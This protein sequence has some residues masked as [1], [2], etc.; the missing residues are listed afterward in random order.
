VA[1]STITIQKATPTIQVSGYSTPFDGLAHTTTGQVYGLG[2]LDLGQAVITYQGGSAPVHGGT[3]TV[4][5]SFAG[6]DNY[7]AATS[8][9]TITITR[10]AATIDVQPA[11]A[12]YD[13][14]AH[15]TSG[16]IY[17]LGGVVIGSATMSYSGGSTPVHAGSYTAT[18]T[19]DG[20]DDYTPATA[21][22]SILINKVAP[23]VTFSPVDVPFSGRVPNFTV[24]ATGLGGEDLGLATIS[25]EI[26]SA[27]TAVGVY[28]ATALFAGNSDY[29]SAVAS[30]T[31]TIH[32]VAATTL[33]LSGSAV[34]YGS[35]AVITLT[36][37]AASGTPTGSV[38][39]TVDSGTPISANLVDGVATF[40]IP[41]LHAGSHTI[42]G[43]YEVTDLYGTSTA[44]VNYTVNQ[45]AVTLTLGNTSQVYGTPA[46]LTTALPG[47]L[48]TGINGENLQIAYSSLGNIA[49]ATVGNYAITG[50]ASTGTGLLS[51][52]DITL[53]NGTLTVTQAP[54]TVTGT[55][56]TMP[57]GSTPA[58]QSGVI[59]GLKNGDAFPAAYSTT[60]T[61][62]SPAGSYPVTG[63]LTDNQGKLANYAVSYVAGTLTLAQRQFAVGS[64]VTSTVGPELTL[65]NLGTFLDADAANWPTTYTATVTWTP[66]GTPQAATFNASDGAISVSGSHP[67]NASA[68]YQPV[69]TITDSGGSTFNLVPTVL[70]DFT[71]PTSAASSP[72]GSATTTF[73]VS[74]TGTDPGA[75]SSGVRNFAVYVSANGGAY[76][77]YNTYTSVSGAASF[78]YTGVYGSYYSFRSIATDNIGNVELKSAS[79]SDTTTVVMATPI[80]TVSSTTDNSNFGAPLALSVTVSTNLPGIGTPT[81]TIEFYDN[82][83]LTSLGT[84]TLASGVAS[85]SSNV[86]AVGVHDIA[87][88][89]SGDSRFQATTGNYSQSIRTSI[90]VTSAT[91]SAASPTGKLALSA[92]A[93]VN[94]P[95]RVVVNSP[96]KPAVTLTGT[97]QLVA[98]SIQVVG[99]VSKAATA[100]LSPSSPLLGAAQAVS[101]PLAGLAVPNVTGAATAVTLSSGSM[102]INP[103]VYSQIKLSG[104]ASLTMNPGVYVIAGG[105]ISV[106]NTASITGVG[107]MLHV[108]NST[109]PAAGGT[110]AGVSFNTTGAVNLSAPA[111]GSY[112]GVL[113]FQA[114]SSTKAITING[115]LAQQFRGTIYATSALLS[116]AGSTIIR[117]AMVV[118]QL[119]VSGTA[120]VLGTG[121]ISATPNSMAF[122]SSAGVVAYDPAQVR[123]AYGISQLAPGNNGAGQTIAIVGA[124]HS[125]NLAASV[126][127]FSQ[128][129]SLSATSPSLYAQYGPAG[130]FLTVVNQAGTTTGTPAVE[131]AGSLFD[132]WSRELIS[133]V[134]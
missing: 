42:Q 21:T 107:V 11:T 100:T 65:I 116:I 118:N 120:Q 74:L 30:S 37:S 124:Y 34:A 27:P 39:L 106:T 20:N 25:Y 55:N 12:N 119:Q 18:A 80:I 89:Y 7:A 43:D 77:L 70:A 48:A 81:G 110:F 31:V 53:A 94:I 32:E 131:P 9:A 76:S 93:V 26:G 16:T 108:T 114:R 62:N 17:G 46:N 35:S 91:A 57:T 113:L 109:Y 111:T 6:N 40:T 41:G 130:S 128:Q 15:G 22:A 2:G 29:L 117:S 129:F 121:V 95:G 71:V 104:T 72:V 78:N 66:G 126:D 24:R 112:A 92:N 103:G 133:N 52:Y 50:V 49:S 134:Q 36:V 75:V 102:T 1:T 122:S 63:L 132:N 73:T 54:L 85:V 19:F 44:S 90:Y 99:T 67:Y 96:V 56:R 88:K 13:G 83:T 51:D 61:A 115:T 14:L 125:P 69:V 79:A 97:S 8:T 3:Y 10:V 84:F 86:L 47:A 82:T 45:A 123:S 87:L 105:G 23:T 4:T 60:A 38:S 58:T 64:T 59:T 33:Q 5:A 68:T 101:D 127:A 28:N 98:S